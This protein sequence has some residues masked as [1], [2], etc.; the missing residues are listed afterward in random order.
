MKPS[1]KTIYISSGQSRCDI[2]PDLGGGLARWCVDGQE[3]LCMARPDAIAVNDP[4]GLSSF[5]LVPY[6]NRIGKAM[7]EWHGKRYQLLRNFPPEPHAIHGVGWQRPWLLADG[8]EAAVTLLLQHTADDTWPWPFEASQTISVSGDTLTL[9]LSAQNLA[10]E[11]AP[12]SF[13]HHP[14][15]DAEGASLQFQAER[16]WLSGA[17][18]L[19]TETAA[20]TGN[21]DFSLST[22]VASHDVDHCY[23]GWNGRAVMTWANRPYSLALCASPELRAAVVYIP[24][25]GKTFC[26]EP[27]PHINNALNMQNHQPAMPII[28]PGETFTAAITLQALPS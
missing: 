6:S 17:D 11:A 1:A 21:F 3:M 28:A 14:Y 18:G 20:P 10:T 25:G 19:P 5:P 2:Y 16:V 7:F 22:P 12:L 4:L 9:N 24:Q 23:A 15:F 27:V 8:S 13:G 26:F